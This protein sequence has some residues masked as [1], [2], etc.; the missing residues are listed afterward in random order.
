MKACLGT[1]MSVLLCAIFLLSHRHFFNYAKARLGNLHVKLLNGVLS[2]RARLSSTRFYISFLNDCLR[3]AVAPSHIRH[4]IRRARLFHTIRIEKIFIKDE[5][6]KARDRLVREKHDFYARYRQTKELLNTFDFIRFSWLLSECD[7]KQRIKFTKKYDGTLK[8]LRKE[9][10]GS[11]QQNY[12]NIIN[13]SDI[14]L[15]TPQKD[16]LCRGL[17]FCVP[18]QPNKEEVL[19]EFELFYERLTDAKPE[20]LSK[21]TDDFCRTSL[22]EIATRMATSKP[23]TKD[24]LL[25]REHLTALRELERN[26]NIVITKPDK[27]RAVVI[28]SKIDYCAKMRTILEDQSKFNCLGPSDSEDDYKR[29]EDDLQKH[30]SRLAKTKQITTDTFNDLRPTGSVRPR[31]YGLPKIHKPTV[32]LRPIISMSGSAQYSIS[33][34]LA[35]L[36]DPVRKIYSTKCIK[37]SFAFVDLLRNAEVPSGGIMCSYDAVSLFTNVPLEDTIDICNKTL[38]HHE[39]CAPAL[40]E[41]DFADL[42]RKVTSGVKFS[43]DNVMYQQC[44]GVAMG[45]PLGPVLADIFVGYHESLIPADQ[46]PYLYGRF[47]D[48]C[49]SYCRDVEESDRFL[50]TLNNLHPALKFTRELE[51]NGVLP[52]LDVKTRREEDKFVTTIYRKPTFT[53]LYI[54]FD[55]FTPFRYKRNLMNNLCDRAI[56]ICSPSELD[57]EIGYLK[58]TFL[59]NGY[60]SSVVRKYVTPHYSK[61]EKSFGP[62]KRGVAL[63][64]PFLGPTSA[65]FEREIRKCV[66]SVYMASRVIFIYSTRRALTVKKDVLPIPQMSSVIYS[67]TCRQCESRYIGR[68]LQHLSTR[69]RQHVPLSL[70]HADQRSL[71]PRRGRPPKKPRTVPKRVDTVS[72]ESSSEFPQLDP[73]QYESSVAKHLAANPICRA[74]YSDTDF[75]LIARGRSLSHLQ[76]LEALFIRKVSPSLCI[77]TKAKTLKLFPPG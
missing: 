5:L 21:S 56:R 34:W 57:E 77:Q 8:F 15:T 54:P 49:F 37:D 9:R 38:Y 72:T 69:V 28:L 46:W 24:F 75:S 47:V 71:R 2:S 33:K 70:L 14:E 52:F 29:I 66:E 68:T 12:S 23:D 1:S 30:L 64:V 41:K 16:I 51:N 39:I 63:R 31:A 61:P 13:F 35:E 59:K 40:G 58:E 4:R 3:N 60:P 10:Y 62:E 50:T 26:D 67:F 36:L 43:F 73:A 32:P 42:M 55:S 74:A 17:N 65:K 45:S 48:D 27:G 25:G 76:V 7:R 6:A 44:D 11:W 19:A 18:R 20:F 22:A 53:G